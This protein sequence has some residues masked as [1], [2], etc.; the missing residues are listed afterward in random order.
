MNFLALLG[1]SPGSDQELFTR[2]EL[3]ATFSLEGISGGSAVFNPEKLEWFNQQHI[4]RLLGE[5]ILARI[6]PLMREAGLWSD[7][8]EGARRP[9]LLKVIE[10]IRPRAH[11]L[12]DF[13]EIGRPLFQDELEFDADAV[14]Q[15][16]SSPDVRAHLAALREEMSRLDLFDEASLETTLRNFAA[17]RGL[18]AGTLIHA[19][20]V[21]VTGRAVS[22]GLFEV[23]ALLGRART[24]TRLE[25]AERL[26]MTEKI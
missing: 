1:W 17:A 26:L 8:Y 7:A 10:L 11:R 24:T 21:A 19:V 5:E 16:F 4:A 6:A 14:K 20:R 3:I 13:V 23:L 25:R 22:P 12:G 15:H 9:W 2:D 18:K